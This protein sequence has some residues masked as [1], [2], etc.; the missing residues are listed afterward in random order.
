M[1]LIGH[2]F[3]H[4]LQELP[5]S[6]SV[7]R[8]NELS[9]SELASAI[10][11][12]EQVKLT[13]GGLHLGD[14]NVK[15]ACGVAFELLPLGLVALDIWQTRDAMPLQTAMQRRPRQVGDRRL[16]GIE[17]VVKRQQRVA[18]E[19]DDRSLFSLGQ[20]RRSWLFRSSLAVLDGCPLSLFGHRLRSDAQLPAQLRERS[21]RSLYC[22]SD[23]VRGRGA[24]VTNFSHNASFH[25]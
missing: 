5:G 7:S 23:G 22:C 9:H 12:D 20:D 16:N 25:S 18:A 3:K 10:N 15:K 17:T 21:L 14:I 1:T 13:F 24:P 6:L 19:R 11:A 4:V 8:C 2:R